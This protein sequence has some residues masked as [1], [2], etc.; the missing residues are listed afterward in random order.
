MI[1]LSLP[2]VITIGEI[3]ID[4]IPS[5]IAKLKDLQTFEKCPGGA[6]ANCAVGIARLGINTAFIGKISDDPFG[7]YLLEIL[8]REGIITDSVIKAKNGEKTSLAF[9]YYNENL[10]RNFFFYRKNTADLKLTP[11]ELKPNFFSKLKYLLFGTVSL[12]EEPV[13]SA[14]F[15]AIELCKKNGGKVCFDP[16]IRLSLWENEKEFSEIL[17]KALLQTD[18]FLPSKDEL[19]F[20]LNKAKIDEQK[21][22][23][24]LFTKYPIE[25]IALKKG[26]DGSIVKK[27]NNHFCEIPSFEVETKDTTGAGDGFNAGFI[28]GL[29]RNLTLEESALIGNAVGAIVVQ[30][31]G[32]MVSLPTIEELEKFLINQNVKIKL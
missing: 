23:D 13:R 20:I 24:E 14:T 1:N 28:Y 22:I 18:I 5:K 9:V 3:L 4:F 15:R 8:S 32:A 16:N 25:I 30:K 31:K 29:V 11:N 17:H 21:L 6:P 27:R 10:E 7:D 12:T 26:K 2:D 19:E